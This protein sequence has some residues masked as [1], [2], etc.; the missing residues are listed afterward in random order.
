MNVCKYIPTFT[1]R[2]VSV[3]KKSLEVKEKPDLVLH[4]TLIDPWHRI[5]KKQTA[6]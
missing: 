4:A 3:G 1:T 5:W 2:V 6:V